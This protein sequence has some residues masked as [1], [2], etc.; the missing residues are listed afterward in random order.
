VP[1]LA[2]IGPSHPFRGGIARTTTALAAALAARGAL[3]AFL[4]PR[5]QYPRW[6]YPGG[7][8][9]DPRAC[10]A[11]D[12][13]QACF[14]VLEP[15][16]WPGLHRRASMTA[17]DAVVVPY[18]TWAWAPL[19]RAVASWGRPLFSVVHNPADH[20]A[21]WLERRAARAVLER[22][23]GFLCH[24]G[25]VAGALAAS[26]PGIPAA[27]HPLPPDRLE[28]PERAPARRRLGLPDGATAFLAFGLLR[29]YKGT[30]LL[31]EAFARLPEGR[32]AVLLL[33]G[34]PWGAL[35]ADL[36][37]RLAGR[38]IAALHW[39]P[40]EE[41]PRW[42]AAADVAVLPYRAA[43]GSAV[44]A[45]ALGAGLPVIASRIGGLAEAVED[46]TS[47]VL[48][49]PGD[50]AALARALERLLEPGERTRLARGAERA[51]ARSNWDSYAAT[52]VE[53]V[54][55]AITT[56]APAPAAPTTRRG[57]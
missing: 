49:P 3:A 24:A 6:L 47:G 40:E 41:A 34:E 18:W 15:W 2:L 36:R 21:G 55:E 46:G 31:L 29:P 13:A 57:R 14:G 23:R 1:R 44:A 56:G 10:P 20:D 26:Y 28:L 30:D 42:F 52:L 11:L 9:V 54:E 5:R 16:T 27:V 8:D 50:V 37:R 48:V 17:A 53:L 25:S 19:A 35:A 39:I 32:P 22:C 4:T 33:A 12:S 43:T 45:Q 7:A 51:A 38:V